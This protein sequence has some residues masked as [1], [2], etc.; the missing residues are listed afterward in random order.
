MYTVWSCKRVFL[1]SFNHTIY[2]QC[3]TIYVIN[4]KHKKKQLLPPRLHTHTHPML[5]LNPLPWK[6]IFHAIYP[7]LSVALQEVALMQ[8]ACTYVWNISIFVKLNWYNV[9]FIKKKTYLHIFSGSIPSKVLRFLDHMNVAAI[10]SSTF[11]NHQ[12]QVYGQHFKRGIWDLWRTKNC[13]WFLV[14][15][16][17]QIHQDILPNTE[18]MPCWIWTSWWLLIF[19]LFR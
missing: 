14:V 6:V 4:Q 10:S 12:F 13:L 7:E 9:F 3:G 2:Q 11:Q 17:E 19:S 15:M 1:F 8:L 18:V 5:L 16:V